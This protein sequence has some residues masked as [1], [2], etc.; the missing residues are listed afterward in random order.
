MN[1]PDPQ[2]PPDARGAA[3][4]APADGR[5]VA[6]CGRCG[7]T[8]VIEPQLAGQLGR[9]PNCRAIVTIPHDAPRVHAPVAAGPPQRS[10]GPRPPTDQPP[11][12][13]AHTTIREAA[14]H[15]AMPLTWA[16]ICCM[17]F[18]AAGLIVGVMLGQ[19][20]MRNRRVEGH[21]PGRPD[22]EPPAMTVVESPHAAGTQPATRPAPP[23]TAPA[24]S[25][26]VP[27]RPAPTTRPR[28][29]TRPVPVPEPTRHLIADVHTCTARVYAISG[30]AGQG[31]P[32]RYVAAPL[33]TLYLLVHLRLK[34]VRDRDVV[35]QVGRDASPPGS[36]IW[37]VAGDDR[38]VCLGRPKA[39]WD[40]RETFNVEP[41]RVAA[42]Q[43][44]IDLTLMF[45]VPASAETGE[46]QIRSAAPVALDLAGALPSP[47]RSEEFT[48]TW[49]R[50]RLQAVK[51]RDPNP[52]ATALAGQRD[53][54]VE[55][56]VSGA[57][58]RVMVPQLMLRGTGRADPSAPH[59]L[60]IVVHDRDTR[61]EC[62]GR[63]AET[64]KLLVLY[65]RDEPFYQIAFVRP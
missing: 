43:S 64:G 21:G 38:R 4:H 59:R 3:A 1:R 34:N 56:E 32:Q 7:K 6:R 54:R 50:L 8:L 10:G 62:I 37:L 25:T 12:A 31:E 29:T 41:I 17:G 24:V 53:L 45:L 13:E 51:P 61:F 36:D 14:V 39:T 28:P 48:G 46:L 57:Q 2:P 23:A 47:D 49:T 15:S 19:A 40:L 52:I 20:S 65:L 35:L 42:G 44:L 33:G 11:T 30:T 18:L 5:I 55:I 16:A 9:C 63:L 60:R 58:Y 26:P 27:T 22:F